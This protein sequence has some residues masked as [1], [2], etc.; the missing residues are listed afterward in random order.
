MENLLNALPGIRLPV[1][2]VTDTLHHMWDVQKGEFGQSQSEFRASQM[3]LILHFGLDTSEEEAQLQFDTAIQ[4]AQRYPCRIIV[5]CP[6]QPGHIEDLLEAKLFSQCYIGSHLRDLCCCEALI[7]GYS[8]EESHSLESQVS[9]WLESDLPVYHWFNRVPANRICDYYLTF[10][11]RCQRV[12]FDGAIEEWDPDSINWPDAARVR[13]LAYARTL[14]LR[15]QLGQYISSIPVA[16][17]LEHLGTLRFAAGPASQAEMK[18][19]WAW[20]R[21]CLLKAVGSADTGRVEQFLPA[22]DAIEALEGRE[23]SIEWLDADG[24]AFIRWEYLP[25]QHAGRFE[26]TLQGTAGNLF[27]H[28]EPITSH[29]ALAEALFF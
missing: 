9:L 19:L 22:M 1:E 28:L 26:C 14:P 15:Q 25:D 2:S 3:N 20:H 11:T 8:I 21:A 16:V 17:L 29:K 7:L 27:S 23:M 24:K 13:D 4:F 10:I 6:A 18:H 12:L 5:L